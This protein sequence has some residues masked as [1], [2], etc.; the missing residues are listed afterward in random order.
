MGPLIPLTFS[1]L[2]Q[3]ASYYGI[4][5]H[6]LEAIRIAE[7]GRVGVAVRNT[8]GSYDLGPFQINTFWIREFRHEG[9]PVDPV[10]LRD[11]G[12]SNAFFAAYILKRE[13]VNTPGHSVYRAVGYYHSHVTAEARRYRERVFRILRRIRRHEAVA[14][15]S[16]T[17]A[18]AK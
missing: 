16:F 1:C 15:R 6:V 18:E 17:L 8:N 3:A 9:H 7:A 5:H 12:C 4:D 14:G 2:L 13:I 10:E 11:N